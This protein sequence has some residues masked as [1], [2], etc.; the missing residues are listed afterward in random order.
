MPEETVAERQLIVSMYCKNLFHVQLLL[1]GMNMQDYKS[2][3]NVEDECENLKT[4]MFE[5]FSSKGFKKAI[6]GVSGGADSTVCC[7]L[8][9]DVLGPSNV[10]AVRM[11][12]GTQADICDANKV[13]EI[14]DCNEMTLNIGEMFSAMISQFTKAG[15]DLNDAYKSNSPARLRMAMLFGLSALV[16]A[17]VINTCNL[18]EDCAWGNFSTLFGD[19]A[20]SYACLQGFTK[21]EVRM[22][23]EYLGLPHDLVWKTPNDGMC[24]KSDE[25]RISELSG[26]KN[27]TYEEFDKFIR[28]CPH[29]FSKCDIQRLI[30]GYKIGKYKNKIVNID[31]YTPSLPNAFENIHVVTIT[32]RI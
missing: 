9:C 20:G 31:H 14:C 16:G 27:F 1:K 2:I 32:G 12:N 24:G 15:F 3:F 23:G 26:V 19:N 13:I 5:W 22:I 25:A 7:K 28:C 17:A 4:H 11:P 21:T 18:S 29:S 6:V 8:A 10:F 30:H